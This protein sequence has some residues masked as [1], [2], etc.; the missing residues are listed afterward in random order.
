MVTSSKKY[1]FAKSV[2]SVKKPQVENGG[3]RWAKKKVDDAKKTF[4]D[5]DQN[6][7]WAFVEL[8]CKSAQIVMG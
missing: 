7:V 3:R 2:T 4:A 6:V 5:F 8:G 1:D